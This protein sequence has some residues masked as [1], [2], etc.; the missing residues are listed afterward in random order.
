MGDAT[1]SR[2]NN[3]SCYL[4]DIIL[5]SERVVV[6]FQLFY[7]VTLKWTLQVSTSIL[8]DLRTLAK[9]QK[10]H[11]KL[12]PTSRAQVTHSVKG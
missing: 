3:C 6:D 11:T 10:I 1:V 8:Q 7:F 9:R 2:K 5:Y 12:R 4:T